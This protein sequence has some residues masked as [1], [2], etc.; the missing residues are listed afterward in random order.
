[1]LIMRMLHI[2]CVIWFISGLL[3]RWLA[4]AQARRAADIQTAGALLRLSDRFERLMAIP[5]SQ[6]VLLFGLITAWLQGQPLLGVLQG[7]RS[8]W[9]LVSLALFVSAIP[10]IIFVLIPRRKLRLS[11]LEAALARGT[12][13]PEL[14]AAL[15]DRAV[16]ASRVVESLI[17]AVI[18]VLMILKPF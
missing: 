11:A 17:V 13:T 4:Y 1:M 16:I 14:R 18:L 3:G 6:A 12:I 8:N 9:L 15:A 5:G 7:A 2:L 10:L